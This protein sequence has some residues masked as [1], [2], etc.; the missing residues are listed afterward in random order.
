MKDNPTYSIIVPV[1]NSEATLV[2]LVERI[3]ATL[4]EVGASFELL[5]IDD[6]S[7][8]GSWQVLKKLQQEKSYIRLIR[9]TR[10]FGQA[11]ASLCGIRKA[12]AETMVLIDDDLQYPPEEIKTLI[13]HFNP[14]EKYILFGVP[15]KKQTSLLKKI[16]SNTIERFLNAIV[17]KGKTKVRFSSF[18]ILTK[19]RF[20]TENYNEQTMQSAQV[21]FTM[22]S[23]H[24]MD[25]VEVAHEKRKKGSSNYNLLKKLKIAFELLLVTTELPTY[26]F[27]SSV[28]IAVPILILIAVSIAIGYSLVISK[29]VLLAMISLCVVLISLGFAALFIYLRSIYLRQLGADAYAIWEER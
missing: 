24:L 7:E 5:L 3:E 12:K 14:E 1:Y 23:P 6:F 18:R 20:D 17:L 19:K 21:F 4:L 16:S 29:T 28:L 8:D 26:I 27:L 11:A 15:K 10:N 25:W 2:E 13:T 9:F 22:V